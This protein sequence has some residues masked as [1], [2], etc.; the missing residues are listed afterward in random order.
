MSSHYY[1]PIPQFGT[2]LQ[3]FPNKSY[4]ETDVFINIHFN[5]NK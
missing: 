3:W 4:T 2:L 1:T 5:M